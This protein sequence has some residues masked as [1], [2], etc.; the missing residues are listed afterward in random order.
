M[1]LLFHTFI[2]VFRDCCVYFHLHISLLSPALYSVSYLQYSHI[3]IP[4]E[5][6]PSLSL[7]QWVNSIFTPWMSA[8]LDKQLAEWSLA[9]KSS[10]VQ[11]FL[12]S[13]PCW[14]TRVKLL[15][16]ESPAASATAAGRG[17][18]KKVTEQVLGPSMWCWKNQPTQRGR[19]Q[20]TEPW[21][22]PG[23]GTPE[24]DDGD[25]ERPFK[26]NKQLNPNSKMLL[27]G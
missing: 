17:S 7:C 21:E 14:Q 1:G 22:R 27:P 18:R 12:T 19:P 9:A 13:G 25:S 11:L 8:T 6:N 20:S 15:V 4:K 2:V 26:C 3:N 10:P 23:P 5:V 16:Y 24:K